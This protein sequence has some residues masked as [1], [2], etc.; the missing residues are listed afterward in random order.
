MQNAELKATLPEKKAQLQN[1][2]VAWNPCITVHA[3][4]DWV[5][6][7]SFYEVQLLWDL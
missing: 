2:K 6:F 7:L 1:H 5:F 3:L 4:I